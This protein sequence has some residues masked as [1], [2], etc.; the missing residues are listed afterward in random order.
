[1]F[2]NRYSSKEDMQMSNRYMEKCLASR[3]IRGMHIKTTMKYYDIPIR[4]TVI[5]KTEGVG[6]CGVVK[7]TSALCWWEC[8]MKQ[9]L[10]NT[11]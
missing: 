8:K 4:K 7:R 6:E 3:I 9:L 11:V 5:K 2:L 1:V 10:G